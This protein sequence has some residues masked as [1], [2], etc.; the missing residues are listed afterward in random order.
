[1]KNNFALIAK[2]IIITSLI[3]GCMSVFES[4]YETISI[5]TKPAGADIYVMGMFAGVSPAKIKVRKASKTVMIDILKLYHKPNRII[6]YSRNTYPKQ[7]KLCMIDYTLG[8]LLLGLPYQI[9]K[10]FSKKCYFFFK[11]DF[12]VELVR[13]ENLEITIPQGYVVK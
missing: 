1:M 5:T 6:L 3:S 8:W 9:D 11:T 10:L 4:K 7:S 13:E 2:L 12:D